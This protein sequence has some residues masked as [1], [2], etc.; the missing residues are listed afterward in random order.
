MSELNHFDNQGRSRMVDVGDKDVTRRRAVAGGIIAVTEKILKLISAGEVKK[1]DVFEVSRVAGIMGGKKTPQLIPMCHPLTLDN[2]EVKFAVEED[3]KLIYVYTVVK[4]RGRTGVEMEALTAAST[5]CLTVYDMCK[6]VDKGIKIKD[7]RLL[8]KSGGKSGDYLAEELSGRAEEFCTSE[9][10]GVTKESVGEVVLRK[11]HGIEGDAHAG[12]WHRQVS[13]LARE[14]IEMMEEKG[15]DLD[16]GD[17]GENIITQG[18]NLVSLPVGTRLSFAQGEVVLELTQK[19]KE[20]HDRCQ[21]YHRTGDC[22]MPRRGV[23]ARV[24]AGGRLEPGAKI[25]V[26][27]DD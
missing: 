27:L 18:F 24:I 17:F 6:G 16:P 10:K 22:I 21:I 3:K 9:K 2:I 13:L 5:A 15:L 26:I 23:F 8:K 11:D 12:D 14:D 25:E 1:G 7:I 4:N 20:C 19:G